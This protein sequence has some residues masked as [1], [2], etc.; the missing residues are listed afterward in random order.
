[1]KK[2]IFLFNVDDEDE[3]IIETLKKIV[4][5]L[6]IKPFAIMHHKICEGNS[7]WVPEDKYLLAWFAY[8]YAYSYKLILN[9]LQIEGINGIE[10]GI[11]WYN[12]HVNDDLYVCI[13]E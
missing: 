13:E 3:N 2:Y 12:R 5:E 6:K 4:P 10:E 9:R 8:S 11:K 1:M 7:I